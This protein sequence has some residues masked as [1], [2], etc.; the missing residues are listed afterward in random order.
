MN[1][2]VFVVHGSNPPVKLSQSSLNPTVLHHVF[3]LEKQSILLLDSGN[4]LLDWNEELNAYPN[5]DTSLMPLQIVGT[6]IA[7]APGPFSSGYFQ[8]PPTPG[9]FPPP[10]ATLG[11]FRPPLPPPPSYAIPGL[12]AVPGNNPFAAVPPPGPPVGRRP[13]PPT[14]IVVPAQPLKKTLRVM[15]TTRLMN[16]KPNKVASEMVHVEIDEEDCSV[17]RINTSIQ[18]K[19]EAFADLVLCNVH[20]IPY[21]DDDTTNKPDFWGFKRG[22]AANALK[23]F[24]LPPPSTEDPLDID[25]NGDPLPKRARLSQGDLSLIGD[26]VQRKLS[27]D[28]RR[29]LREALACVKC[30]NV[31][32][33]PIVCTVTCKSVVGCKGCVL[34]WIQEQEDRGRPAACLKCNSVWPKDDAVDDYIGIL[35]LNGFDIVIDKL[36]YA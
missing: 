14:P 19:K 34:N 2:D 6:E 16:G 21:P 28:I 5:L 3:K 23:F 32:Y 11:G 13:R 18:S 20:G 15:C 4:N 30:R 8:P 22:T 24:A 36:D 25:L 26:V 7:S 31:A 12:S 1:P 10:P 9:G 17:S 35:E 27:E 33:Q 29:P